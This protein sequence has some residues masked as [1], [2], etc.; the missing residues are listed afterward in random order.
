MTQYE[1][2]LFYNPSK[3]GE[4]F[5]SDI[6]QMFGLEIPSEE[7][8]IFY[9]ARGRQR[10]STRFSTSNKERVLKLTEIVMEIPNIRIK[11]DYA[12]GQYTF[13]GIDK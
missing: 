2:E 1:I 5:I 3:V 13:V 6:Y 4:N 7:R 11:I 10:A 8:G 12:S 9:D